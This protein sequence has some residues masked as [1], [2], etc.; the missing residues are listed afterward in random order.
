MNGT[1]KPFIAYYDVQD[2]K[3]VVT[4]VNYTTSAVL[5]PLVIEELSGVIDAKM[6]KI[7]STEPSDTLVF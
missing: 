4:L 2:G 1:D 5:I 3:G 6:L 7:N